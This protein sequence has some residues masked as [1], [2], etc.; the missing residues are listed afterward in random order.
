M[1]AK[2]ILLLHSLRKAATIVIAAIEDYTDHPYDKS[3]LANRRHRKGYSE[4]DGKG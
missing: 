4:I 1:D 2:L 3:A